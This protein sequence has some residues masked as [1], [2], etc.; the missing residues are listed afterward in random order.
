LEDAARSIH[1]QR[2][3][4]PDGG[5]GYGLLRYLGSPETGAQL[6][7]DL[8]P[9]V[10]FNFLGQIAPPPPG[11]FSVLSWEPDRPCRGVE[12]MPAAA[13]KHKLAIEAMI[14]NHCLIVDWKF[15]PARLHFAD[16]EKAAAL[17][18]TFVAQ[19]ISPP[20]QNSASQAEL[21]SAQSAP[22]ERF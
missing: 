13:R 3:D 20:K 19:L 15:N 7:S 5:A 17:F 22:C 4:I 12:R 18:E 6:M 1:R 11:A 16:I 21:A 10:A 8:R 2:A 14:S 9:E